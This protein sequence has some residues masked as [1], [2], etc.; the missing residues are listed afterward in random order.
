[1]SEVDFIC[2]ILYPND[3]F[4]TGRVNICVI[5]IIMCVLHHNSSLLGLEMLSSI[6]RQSTWPVDKDITS[7]W[8]PQLLNYASPAKTTSVS[9]NSFLKPIDIYTIIG[10]FVH[11]V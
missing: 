6:S 10:Q 2:I 4:P 5:V 11:S 7:L 1:M 9:G 8:H 3:R